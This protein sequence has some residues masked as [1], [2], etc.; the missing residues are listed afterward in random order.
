MNKKV[1][2]FGVNGQDGKLLS[3]YLLKKNYKI[4]GTHY[5]SIKN[6]HFTIIKLNINDFKKVSSLIKRFK[7]NEIYN[8]AGISDLSSNE[9]NFY[10]SE[11]TNNLAVIN[12]LQSIKNTKIK[13]F[14][15]ITS[16]IYGHYKK[17]KKI[18]KNTIYNPQSSYAIS[19]LSSMFY[20][21]LFREK[22]GVHAVSGIL[23]SHES[24]LRKNKFVTK[25]II[26]NLYK[27]KSNKISDFQ[28]YNINAKRDW[29]YA[30]DYVKL[31]HK[32]T[33][34]KK[35]DDYFIGTGKLHSVKEIVDIASKYFGIKIR[36][37]KTSK[38][39]FGIDD[40]NKKIIKSYIKK[41]EKLKAIYADTSK[42][43][44]KFNFRPSISFK[45]LIIYI[46]K[47]EK[48]KNN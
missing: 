20:I 15:P 11:K 31:I 5:K 1:L 38:H 34:R 27:L 42:I 30:R 45:D 48:L 12:I 41:N 13:Y 46:C 18:D 23:F 7:P 4:I 35:A 19:K 43:L 8:F 25:M 10:L 33:N 9:K 44:K 16:E 3:E 21:R 22:F 24:E 47:H 32:C 2:I 37:K 26:E 28:I 39:I 29:G 6:K 40:N 14:Q 36:W 17:E